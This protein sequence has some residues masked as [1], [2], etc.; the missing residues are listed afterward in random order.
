MPTNI[1]V[2]ARVHDPDRLR[3]LAERISDTPVEVLHQ[4]DT[5]FQTPH[6]RLKLRM[7]AP[8]AGELIYYERLDA[9]GPKASRY[10][11]SHTSEPASL[12]TVLSAVLP[13][14]G[15]VRKQRLL[16]MAGSTRIHIDQVER[17]GAFME[18]EVQLQPGQSLEEGQEIANSLLAQLEIH[19]SDL[20][21][22]AYMDMLEQN[23]PKAEP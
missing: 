6:G 18:L 9:S 13:V 17:L 5:F 7:L 1:E 15:V 10:I 21:Q 4:E 8:D 16:Y 3:Q 2:K 22:G 19:P 11:L 23:N 12:K 14:R 20:I